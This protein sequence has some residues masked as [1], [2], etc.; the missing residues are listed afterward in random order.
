MTSLKF[1]YNLG[2]IT[3]TRHWKRDN[4]WVAYEP[5]IREM[6]IWA[7]LFQKVDILAPLSQERILVNVNN[8][9]RANVTIKSV[10]YETGIRSWGWLIRAIQL[11]LLFW[12]MFFFVARHEVILVRSPGHFGLLGN[13]LVWTLRKKSITKFAGYFGYFD[14]ER[15]P[16][17]IERWFIRNILKAPHYVLI[18][19][20]SVKSHLIS[21]IPA[22]MSCNEISQLQALK[23]RKVTESV[24]IYSLGKLIP[25]KGFSLP[26]KA[27]GLLEKEQPELLWEYHLIGEGNQKEYLVNLVKELEISHKVFFEGTLP[28]Q[29]AMKKLACA[30]IVLMPGI[31]EGWPKVIIEGWTLGAVPLVAEAGISSMIIKDGVN[32][33]LFKAE[34]VALK[35]K[36][37]A[38]FSDIDLLSKIRERG[39]QEVRHFSTEEFSR[40]IEDVCR[41]KLKL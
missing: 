11:P 28:Y 1:N 24:L 27:L 13:F 5:Y 31:K 21:F 15:V 38:I 6:R 2:V 26:L 22:V 33:L 17:I 9:D 25:V 32:G 10:Y 3:Q 30:D 41:N 35:N 19:G 34:P 14:G 7:D 39:N 36:L 37:T 4:E 29:Q 12:K 20:P 18:Y 16:S 23:M 40:R 8:Y